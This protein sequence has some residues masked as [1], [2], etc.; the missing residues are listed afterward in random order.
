M[1][2]ACAAIALVLCP[3]PAPA[4]VQNV[5]VRHIIAAYDARLDAVRPPTG[6]ATGKVWN[7]G[8]AREYKKPS[9]VASLVHDGDIVEIDAG[10]YKC[11]AGV[12]WTRN[13]LTLVGVGGR[14]VLDATGCGV[15]GGKG[16]WNPYGAGMVV[17]NIE[18]TGATVGDANGAGIRYDGSGYLYITNCY[19]HDNQE[20]ILYTPDERAVAN[21]DIV[22]DHTEFAHNGAGNGLSHNLYINRGNSL[23]MRFSYS[24][25][26]VVGHQLK[27]RLPINYILYNRLADEDDGNGSYEIDVPNGG[28]TYIIGNV[29]QKGP[30]QSNNNSI[31]YEVEGPPHADETLYIVNNTIIGQGGPALHVYDSP[32]L[33]GR[34][35]NNL[36][37]GASANP[38]D[39]SGEGKIV[40]TNNIYTTTPGFHDQA[41]RSYYLTAHSE[42]VDKGINPGLGGTFP[43]TPL[44]EFVYPASGVP[45][46][47]VGPL[48]VGAYEYQ[49]GQ[50]IPDEP[51]VTL[52]AAPGT[53]DYNTNTTL[54]WTTTGA[55]ACSASGAW[56]GGQPTAGTF[57]TAKMLSNK[58]YTLYCTGPG[59]GT[60]QSVKIRVNESALAASLGDYKWREIPNSSFDTVC[61]EKWKDAAGNYIYED[62]FGN[63]GGPLCNTRSLHWTSVYVPET[64]TVYFMGGFTPR[65]TSDGNETYGFNVAQLKPQL[66][67][68]PTHLKD[69]KEWVGQ[70]NQEVPFNIPVCGSILHLKDGTVVPAVRGIDGQAAYYPKD[71][72]I[73]VGPGGITPGGLQNCAPEGHT[74]GVPEDQWEFDPLAAD[75]LPA[76]VEKVWRLIAEPDQRFGDIYAGFP[77]WILDPA[78]GIAFYADNYNYRER[79]GYLIDYNRTPPRVKLVNN[80]FPFDNLGRATVDTVNHYALFVG[81]GQFGIW[82]LNGLSLDRY[83]TAG[84]PGTTG[85]VE[86][87]QPIFQTEP[88]WTASGDTDGVNV[89]LAMTYNS[90]LQAWVGWDAGT[91]LYFFFPDYKRKNINIVAKDDLSSSP[92][93]NPDTTASITYIPDHDFYVVN[94]AWEGN[95]WLLIPPADAVRPQS[96]AAGSA[97]VPSKKRTGAR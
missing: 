44:Y 79:G 63:Y 68:L 60:R 19:F 91:T 83:G 66:I 45:R 36:I 69:T 37:V 1:S 41:R 7:V 24:H 88:G 50:V 76:P 81:G 90:K 96:E 77:T 93:R 18:F 11:D 46:P 47:T 94:A 4:Q 58:T 59:G 80:V 5:D 48:D 33:S 9:D 70:F 30:H 34:M 49:P 55:T 16:I 84:G 26:A 52:A 40:S 32:Q 75:P 29:I 22:I 43:L 8:A 27:T 97:A 71:R 92:K 67:T 64:Q 85:V 87:P 89:P 51:T 15:P 3:R 53:I 10:V 13:L 6:F 65:N 28:L 12:R 2:A 86:G 39:G 72:K 20:G 62:I 35:I 23:V 57:T 25:D 95:F 82:N 74:A 61:P 54:R 14:A 31:S 56:S 78:S 17:A 73:I 21:S 38:I 42:A